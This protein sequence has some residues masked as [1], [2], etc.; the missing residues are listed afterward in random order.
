MRSYIFLVLISMSAAALQGQSVI[1]LHHSTGEGVFVE[2][3]VAAWINNYNSAN[4]T[5]YSVTE[6]SYPDSPY[7]W[8]N[9][10]YDYWNLWVNNQCSATSPNI[11]CLN[12]MLQSYDVVIFKHCFPGAGIAPDNGIPLISSPIK[13]IANYKLQYRALRNLMDQYPGKKF[14]IWTLAPLHRLETTTEEAARAREFVNWVKTS[15]LTEDGK[16][17]PN[18]FIFDFFGLVAES[19]L[20]P[21]TGKVNCLK[22]EYEKSHTVVDSHPNL[23]ANQTVGPQFSQFIINTLKGQSTGINNDAKPSGGVVIYPNPG[24]EQ[25][26]VD[27]LNTGE[28]SI[29]VEMFNIMGNRIYS[30]PV[31]E[32]TMLSL[33]TKGLAAGTYIL[34]ITAGQ[35]TF[36]RKI[37]VTGR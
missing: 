21:V 25:I 12:T 13:T 24:S 15:W 3:N 30:T 2:G 7:P 16:A 32:E 14:I 18:I 33:N 5:A 11:Q 34:R 36:T 27:V 37:A 26:M 9:Y 35:R 28:N 19:N 1:F 29:A 17:H 8:E 6:R 31:F 4:G 20:T 22:Y 23:L 10:P